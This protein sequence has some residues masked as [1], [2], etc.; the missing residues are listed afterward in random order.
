MLCATEFVLLISHLV[1]DKIGLLMIFYGT[2]RV[3][4][5]FMIRRKIAKNCRV[6]FS[7]LV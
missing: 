4:P 7:C 1:Y 5:K 3:H 6:L 2:K